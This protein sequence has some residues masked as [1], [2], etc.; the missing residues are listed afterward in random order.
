MS[1]ADWAKSCRILRVA[2]VMLARH[3]AHRQWRVLMEEAHPSWGRTWVWPRDLT[4]VAVGMHQGSGCS[5]LARA[6]LMK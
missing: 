1:V 2:A 5:F 6:V 4:S 3:H